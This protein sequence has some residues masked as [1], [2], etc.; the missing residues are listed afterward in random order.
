MSWIFKPK[1]APRKT[2][3]ENRKERYSF[4]NTAKWRNLRLYKLAENPLC[5]I[6]EKNNIITLADQIHHKKSFME[7]KTLE[8][9]NYFFYDFTNLLSICAKCHGELHANQQKNNH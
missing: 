8:E 1:K 7:G 6:C 2:N 4:Y 3:S 5:E 9:K